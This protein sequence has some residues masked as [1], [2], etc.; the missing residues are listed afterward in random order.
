MLLVINSNN[1]NTVFGV[2]DGYEKRGAWR[3]STD[4]RRTADEYAVWLTQLMALED[5]HR[6][7][8]DG[9]VLSN[10]VPQTSFHMKTLCT[11]Y[12]GGE[13]VTVGDPNV[14]IGIRVLLDRPEEAG[15]DRLANAVAARKRYKM[16]GIVIDLGTATTFDV[17]DAE[18]N[19]CGG[20]ISPGITMAF[21]ALYMG[22]A[23]L[24]RIEI[25]R[26]AH[27][28]GHATVSAMQSG[29]F[30]GYIG[31]IEGLV[32]RIEAELGSKMT[33]IGT[34][35]LVPLIADSTKIIQHVDLDLTLLGLVDIYNLNR[36]AAG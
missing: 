7:H 13:P 26:P 6:H 28:V 12:F 21:E 23:K 14:K 5:I 10:V 17:L 15:A 4:A 30:W 18:G 32:A 31:L 25:R 2:F 27:V 20:A 16:P 24:P 33:I 36:P 35:G 8:I 22:A 3:I 19:Y 29:I 9:V 34:G 11:R 1:T